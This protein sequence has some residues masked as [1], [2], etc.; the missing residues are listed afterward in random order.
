MNGLPKKKIKVIKDGHNSMQ[1]EELL[2]V[3][4]VTKIDGILFNPNDNLHGE[5][6][7]PYENRVHKEVCYFLSCVAEKHDITKFEIFFDIGSLNGAEG[8]LISQLLPKCRVYSFEANPNSANI[9]VHNQKNYPNTQCINNALGDENKS[10]KFYI[11]SHPGCSSILKPLEFPVANE[12]KVDMITGKYFCETENIS[13]VDLLW[14]D[15]QGFEL[16]VLKGF[17]EILE[18]VKGI[19]A[20]CGLRPTYESRSMYKDIVTYLK[21]YGF[22][23]HMGT[24]NFEYEDKSK[25]PVENDFIFIK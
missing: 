12:I 20:E 11:A 10:V 18:T 4:V 13:I 3:P 2:A 22:M 21:Q 19:H 9:I 24:R 23:Q 1:F 5:Y 15:V 14:I 8:I 16:N 6:S 7:G 25:T 17:G